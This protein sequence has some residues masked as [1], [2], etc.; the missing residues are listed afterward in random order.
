MVFGLTGYVVYDKVFVTEEENTNY[1]ED[2]SQ[3]VSLP[4][5]VN[6]LISFDLTLT[7]SIWDTEDNECKFENVSIS[8]YDLEKILVELSTKNLTKDYYGDI[9]PSGTVCSDRFK[10]KYGD[11]TISLESGGVVWVDDSMLSNRLDLDVDNT[12]GSSN[13][14]NYVYRFDVDFATLINNYKVNK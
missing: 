9:S 8:T 12:D 5:W 6:Y 13:S 11:N 14:V 7:E 2:N 10:L 3:D 1:Q 4:K